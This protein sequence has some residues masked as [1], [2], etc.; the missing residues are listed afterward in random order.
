LRSVVSGHGGRS[1]DPVDDCGGG[2]TS[3]LLVRGLNEDCVELDNF[4]PARTAK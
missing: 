1:G 4:T 2:G 3:K